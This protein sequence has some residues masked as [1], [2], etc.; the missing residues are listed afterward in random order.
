MEVPGKP[1]TGSVDKLKPTCLPSLSDT[2]DS[3][4]LTGSGCVCS[5]AYALLLGAVLWPIAPSSAHT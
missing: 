3:P 1:E 4:V 2:S 5:H